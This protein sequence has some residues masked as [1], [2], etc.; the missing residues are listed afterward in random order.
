MR[1]DYGFGSIIERTSDNPHCIPSLYSSSFICP[2]SGFIFCYKNVFLNPQIPVSDKFVFILQ[3]KLLFKFFFFKVL[4]RVFF[5][6][7]NYN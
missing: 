3:Q 5:K 1:D 4:S 2:S 7:I 6:I